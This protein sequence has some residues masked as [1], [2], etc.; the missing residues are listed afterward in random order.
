MKDVA[1]KIISVIVVFACVAGLCACTK[2]NSD[3]NDVVTTNRPLTSATQAQKQTD[4]PS[5]AV[6]AV[7]PEDEDGAIKL[8][9]HSLNSFRKNSFNFV[10]KK[11][12]GLKSFSAGS[13]ASVQGATESYKSMLKSSFGDMMGV[14]NS[15]NSYYVGDDISSVFVI[16]EMTSDNISKITAS[17]DGQ[18]VIININLL[19]NSDDGMTEVGSVT[20]DYMTVE[21]FNTKIKEYAASADSVSVKNGP[22]G[23]TAE[24]DYA[25]KNFISLQI[26]YSTQFSA[27]NVALS[28]VSGGPVTG[29]T[30][31]KITFKDFKEE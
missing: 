5:Q 1:L 15:E 9:N 20:K 21:K 10:V 19:K 13:L 28:Y 14:G 18:K 4:A 8:F 27:D 29:S 16:P 11:E 23:I 31:T 26:S 3:N 25:T 7:A 2:K 6:S 17:A 22:V 30:S 12:C 24:I